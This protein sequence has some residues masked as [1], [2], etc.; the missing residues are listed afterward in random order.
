MPGLCIVSGG[1]SGGV[2]GAGAF[3]S[4]RIPD[5]SV[6]NL[7]SDHDVGERWVQGGI[8]VA[9][10]V[11]ND[12][13]KLT[14]WTQEGL[15]GGTMPLPTSVT[16]VVSNR[17]VRGIRIEYAVESR[18][19]KGVALADNRN[20]GLIAGHKYYYGVSGR[21]ESFTVTGALQSAQMTINTSL[22]N[23]YSQYGG[24]AS[25]YGN[26]GNAA[27]FENTVV[28]NGAIF[29]ADGSSDIIQFDCH[30]GYVGMNTGNMG[31]VIVLQAPTLVDLTAAFGPGNEPS[32]DKCNAWFMA[33]LNTSAAEDFERFFVTS[34]AGGQRVFTCTTS[35]ET[36]ATWREDQF[37]E[38]FKSVT[39]GMYAATG[40][41]FSKAGL[42][43]Y[44]RSGPFVYFEFEASVGTATTA[45]NIKDCFSGLPTPNHAIKIPVT[46]MTSAGAQTATVNAFLIYDPLLTTPVFPSKATF[47]LQSVTAVAVNS[48]IRASGWYLAGDMG[49]V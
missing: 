4:D 45:G 34:A 33:P 23:T 9:N 27:S 41:S 8:P 39:E 14:R 5:G 10:L 7:S 1:A 6:D 47:K 29:T 43:R 26:A 35:T 17:G 3:I 19:N 38:A 24:S 32:E 2:G 13:D 37:I 46:Q 20:A 36:M 22:K 11:G 44:Y 49:N 16:S 40:F 18:F 28:S 21:I 12:W 15:S 42:P 30:M 25:V 48:V 31:G